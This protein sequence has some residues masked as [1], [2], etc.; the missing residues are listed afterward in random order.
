[1][2]PTGIAKLVGEA[3]QAWARDSAAIGIIGL[4]IFKSCMWVYR[5]GGIKGIAL[6]LWSGEAKPKPTPETKKETP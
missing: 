1:M 3:T 5:N 2:E 4:G 6:G